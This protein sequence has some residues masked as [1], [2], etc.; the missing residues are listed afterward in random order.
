MNMGT[1]LTEIKRPKKG[2]YRIKITYTNKLD[3]PYETDQLLETHNLPTL[4]NE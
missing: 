4:N 3:S 2:P 1:L